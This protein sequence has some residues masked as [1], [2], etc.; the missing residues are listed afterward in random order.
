MRIKEK[1]FRPKSP[2]SRELI[3]LLSPMEIRHELIAI[4]K[5]AHLHPLTLKERNRQDRLQRTIVR[6][7]LAGIPKNLRKKEWN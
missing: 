4:R 5:K 7:G 1:M 2:A 6:R 3:R